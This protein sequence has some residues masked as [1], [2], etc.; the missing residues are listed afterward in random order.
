MYVYTHECCVPVVSDRVEVVETQGY[1]FRYI[2][3]LSMSSEDRLILA[4]YIDLRDIYVPQFICVGSGES[5]I[6]TDPIGLTEKIREFASKCKG[7]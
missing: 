5:M 6:L 1:R 7:E 2:D 4:C 3:A